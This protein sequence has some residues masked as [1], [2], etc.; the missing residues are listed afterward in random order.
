[1]LRSWGDSGKDDVTGRTRVFECPRSGGEIDITVDG[2]GNSTT[3][4]IHASGAQFDC[5]PGEVDPYPLRFKVVGDWEFAELAEALALQAGFEV[6]DPL[7]QPDLVDPVELRST[8]L[9][10]LDQS[11]AVPEVVASELL[12]LTVGHALAYGLDIDGLAAAMVELG[13]KVVVV[14]MPPGGDA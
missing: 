10:L 9:N 3:Y 13:S 8:F 5:R 14:E 11:G 4:S 7:D 1:M 2:D 6:V 12:R